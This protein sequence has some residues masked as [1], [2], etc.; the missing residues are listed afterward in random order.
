MQV[1]KRRVITYTEEQQTMYFYI[2][3]LLSTIETMKMTCNSRSST[4]PTKR[5]DAL[6]GMEDSFEV[7]ATVAN[8]YLPVSF[9]PKLR[10][11]MKKASF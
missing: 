7:V 4:T 9:G 3:L 2:W 6:M 10:F 5:I 11:R 8:S 1:L